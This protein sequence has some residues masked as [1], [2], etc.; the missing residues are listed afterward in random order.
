MLCTLILYIS[1]GNYSLKSTVKTIF[2][3]SF[4]F[5][6]RKPLKKYF[7]SLLISGQDYELASYTTY[8]VHINFI[9]K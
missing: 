6:E 3:G 4:L 2:H 8:V 7:I 1:G 5:A 9:Y